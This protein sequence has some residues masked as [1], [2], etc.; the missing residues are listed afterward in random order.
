[1]LKIDLSCS[2]QVAAAATMVEK[3]NRKCDFGRLVDEMTESHW[4]YMQSIG[5]VGEDCYFVE[6]IFRRN[7]NARVLFADLNVFIHQP[8]AN[9]N[10][11][12][13]R[14]KR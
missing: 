13:I 5:G 8:H 1:M 14:F 4:I 7:V 2:S 12:H 11:S 9:K 10:P 6:I 3:S